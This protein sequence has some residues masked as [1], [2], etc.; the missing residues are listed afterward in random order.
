MEIDMKLVLKIF[1]GLF[2]TL[3]LMLIISGYVQHYEYMDNM[4]SKETQT[5]GP[6]PYYTR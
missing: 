5:M 2:L 1:G 6:Q 4:H 3:I